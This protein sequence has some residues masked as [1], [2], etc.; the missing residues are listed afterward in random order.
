[1]AERTFAH[2]RSRSRKQISPRL[3]IGFHVGHSRGSSPI[4]DGRG[5]RHLRRHQR[6]RLHRRPRRCLNRARL[7]ILFGG[8]RLDIDDVCDEGAGVCGVSSQLA[9]V[10]SSVAA[11]VDVDD[12]RVPLPSRGGGGGL[13]QA[14]PCA[15]ASVLS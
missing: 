6:R 9:V 12:A 10:P 1:M 4:D 5:A 3:P 13:S 11:G 8:H 15:A 14:V 7:E 2:G